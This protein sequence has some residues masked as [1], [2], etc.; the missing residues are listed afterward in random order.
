MSPG[1]EAD[2]A[3]LFAELAELKAEVAKLARRTQI[4]EAHVVDDDGHCMT[5][6]Y[7]GEYEDGTADFVTLSSDGINFVRGLKQQV[8]GKGNGEGKGNPP[9]TWHWHVRTFVDAPGQHLSL[10]PAEKL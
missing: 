9:G 10:V 7:L 8:E 4:V 3:K 6:V 5:S 2:L 1:V